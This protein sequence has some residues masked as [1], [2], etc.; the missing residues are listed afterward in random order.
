MRRTCATC[1][2]R[3]DVGLLDLRLA[4]EA[5]ADDQRVGRS[6]T[7]RGQQPAMSRPMRRSSSIS[8]SEPSWGGS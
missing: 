7:D 2:A 6:L 5:V 3:R 8:W 1:R 4:R